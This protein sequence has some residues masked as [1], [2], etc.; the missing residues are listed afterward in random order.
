[1]PERKPDNHERAAA[2]LDF[3]HPIR[4][5]CA[6]LG[7]SVAENG[8]E[9]LFDEI[10][11]LLPEAWRDQIRSFPMAAL[12]VGLGLGIFLGMKKSEEVITAGTT[13]VSAA[14]MSNLNGAFERFKG[15]E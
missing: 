9:A 1:M 3:D 13:L 10:E 6:T 5:R 7:Q 11:N 4:E 12:A 15:G 14:A 8:P 2:G